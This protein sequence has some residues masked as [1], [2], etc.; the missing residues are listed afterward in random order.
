MEDELKK[1]CTLYSEICNRSVDGKG[2]SISE[3]KKKYGFKKRD[4]VVLLQ[5]LIDVADLDHCVDFVKYGTKGEVQDVDMD[6]LTESASDGD[7]Y[8]LIY[9]NGAFLL[10][11]RIDEAELNIKND[12]F[13]QNIKNDEADIALKEI[14]NISDHDLKIFV[15]NKGIKKNLR[16]ERNKRMKLMMAILSKNM[17]KV[18]IK[19]EVHDFYV[20]K[21]CPLGMRY[22]KL[23]EV[24]E[25][26]YSENNVNIGKTDVS[27]IIQ[28][29]VLEQKY[30]QSFNIYEY[31]ESERKTKMVLDVY[32]EGKVINKL[33]KLLAEYK[34]N[35]QK[36]KDCME[37]SFMIENAEMFEAF[38]KSYGRSVIVIEP[39]ELRE[40]IYQDSKKVLEFYGI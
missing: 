8:I 30:N 17:I 11:D 22:I 21:I 24:Y 36:K 14:S 3:I 1:A 25:L 20:K 9:D 6:D 12:T 10:Q 26:I 16:I 18:K 19:G 31:I 5:F 34:V 33:D 28:I 23:R 35:K 32:D 4:I 2:M 40:K 7:I 39:V 37:Y 15:I 29:E 27:D 38:V 13:L